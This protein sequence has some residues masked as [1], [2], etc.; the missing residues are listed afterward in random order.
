MT[1]LRS[2]RLSAILLAAPLCFG[3]CH[4]QES[5]T[6]SPAPSSQARFQGRM[7]WKET[8]VRKAAIFLRPL[9]PH[10]GPEIEFLTRTDGRFDQDLPPGPYLLRSAPTTMCPV[11]GTITL[12][13][14]INR[15]RL[16]VHPLSFLTCK[17]GEIR[18]L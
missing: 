14:G 6:P 12:S 9:S 4:R 17:P 18:K 13:P 7:L 5:A 8:P 11:R 15:Y 3:A 10:T 2:L 16:L 1:T